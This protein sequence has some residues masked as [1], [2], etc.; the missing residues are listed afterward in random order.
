[1]NLKKIFGRAKRTIDLTNSSHSTTSTSS[2]TRCGPPIFACSVP[3]IQMSNLRLTTNSSKGGSVASTCSKRYAATIDSGPSRPCKSLPKELQDGSDS[4]VDRKFSLGSKLSD[5]LLLSVDASP[6]SAEGQDDKAAGD[7]SEMDEKQQE[8][9]VLK[10]WGKN[11]EL[12]KLAIPTDYPDYMREVPQLTYSETETSQLRRKFIAQKIQSYKYQPLRRNAKL[13]QPGPQPKLN[14]TSSLRK[15]YISRQPIMSQRF[16][17]HYSLYNRP[18]FRH[19][20]VKLV[21]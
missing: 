17:S 15:S 10:A 18:P 7:G 8:E 5:V 14:K 11:L 21:Y 16:Q 1:M 2:S 9:A 12:K 4:I 6:A 3:S 19:T 13:L 20:N